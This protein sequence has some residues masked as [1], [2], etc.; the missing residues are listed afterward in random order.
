MLVLFYGQF[1]VQLVLLNDFSLLS[2]INFHKA[3]YLIGNVLTTGQNIT[4][5]KTIDLD[6]RMEIGR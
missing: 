6:R 5:S 3:D 2:H 4:L 1:K